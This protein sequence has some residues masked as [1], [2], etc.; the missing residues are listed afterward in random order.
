ML[1]LE[2]LGYNNAAEIMLVAFKICRG[3]WQRLVHITGGELELNK[4]T[5]L[6]MTWKPKGGKEQMCNIHDAPG[7]VSLGSE[8]YKGREVELNCHEATIKAER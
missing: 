6:A 5:Y 4:S 1:T 8:K 2:N 7:A 3:I